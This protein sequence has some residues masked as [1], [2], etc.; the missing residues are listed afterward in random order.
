[1]LGFFHFC[2]FA[3]FT[4]LQWNSAA[5]RSGISS[6]PQI[7]PNQ[8]ALQ[9]NVVFT[10]T[11]T[12]NDITTYCNVT[13]AFILYYSDLVHW[14]IRLKQFTTLYSINYDV[15]YSNVQHRLVDMSYPT[16]L[17]HSNQAFD[18]YAD[19]LLA[20]ETQYSDKLISSA[21]AVNLLLQTWYRRTVNNKSSANTDTE[22][23]TGIDISIATTSTT[24]TTAHNLAFDD[25]LFINHYSR[26]DAHR[27]QS[28]TSTNASTDGNSSYFVHALQVFNTT[29]HIIPPSLLPTFL[30]QQ[31]SATYKHDQSA[32]YI[33]TRPSTIF[34]LS[35]EAYTGGRTAML[36][37][38]AALA[39]LGHDV[40]V[41]NETNKAHAYCTD[42][43]GKFT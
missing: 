22:S 5:N 35:L 2:S 14:Q 19:L 3:V 11:A 6:D 38:S 32:Q 30:L 31:L 27:S 39:T 17:T 41:C 4:L 21:K 33:T 23:S 1:M 25:D 13:R 37:L 15:L 28:V 8:L 7:R 43:S 18:T 42:P 10:E 34:Y 26:D 20:T 9:L 24:S 36:V 29:L 16:A 40:L 12:I